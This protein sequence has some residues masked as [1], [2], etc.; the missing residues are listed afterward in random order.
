MKILL[1]ENKNYYKANLHCHTTNSDGT[2]T[3][4][5][6]KRAYKLRGYSAVAFTDHE[7]VIDLS[8]LT[9][10]DF[11]AILG[12]EIAIKE[13]PK[14]ST[15]S[16]PCMRAT[17]LCLYAKKPNNTLTPCY[18][19]VY[20]HFVTPSAEGKFTHSGEYER[21]WCDE[22]IREIID[23]SHREGFLVSYNHPG[24]SLEDARTY[25]G[26]GNA[27]FVE[28]FNTGS[29]K[30][31]LYDDEAAFAEMLRAGINI[32]CTAA[33]DNHNRHPLSSPLSDSFGGFIMINAEK[34]GYKELISALEA[35]KFYASCG[36]EIYSLLLDGD[37]VKVRTSPVRQISCLSR[38]R[39]SRAVIAHAGEELTEA[40]FTLGS[41]YDGFRLK[42]EDF[43]GKKAY[44]QF[45]TLDLY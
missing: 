29:V 4:E 12:C 35:G 44:T 11:V 27:D 5:Q 45:Y 39:R 8:Y 3:P 19:S 43:S 1:D 34:L 25:L 31:G 2:L 40:T 41:Q 26:Y 15:M 6:I 21:R 10:S 7:H 37:K 17:H 36:P 24:W 30:K 20:D 14:A 42:I 32:F 22:G 33:D 38:G 28:I 9:D 18:C 13:N 23:I 16:D